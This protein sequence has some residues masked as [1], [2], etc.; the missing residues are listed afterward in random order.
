MYSCKQTYGKAKI[1][2]NVAMF[3][4]LVTANR[5]TVFVFRAI[6]L[7]GRPPNYAGP[8]KETRSK[9]TLSSLQGQTGFKQRNNARGLTSEEPEKYLR[10][11]R[12]TLELLNN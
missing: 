10:A 2:L 1:K 12:P 7:F 4:V 3:V 8:S 5:K 6:Q 11:C 9:Q